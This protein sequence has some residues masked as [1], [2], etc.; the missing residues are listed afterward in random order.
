MHPY[1]SLGSPSD[2]KKLRCTKRNTQIHKIYVKKKLHVCTYSPV[3]FTLRFVNLFVEVSL[4][5]GS[6]Q[7]WAIVLC[8]RDMYVE[9]VPDFS[10]FN[11]GVGFS[12]PDL[13]K[14]MIV[15][16]LTRSFQFYHFPSK[17]KLSWNLIGKLARIEKLKE[18]HD[19]CAIKEMAMKARKQWFHLPPWWF[20]DFFLSKWNIPGA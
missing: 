8:L 6:P 20:S 12:I 14:Q 17:Q 2:P 16:S 9:K 7:F 15:L 3:Q 19:S 18:V 4:V 10:I 5:C 11:S 13:T 1:G